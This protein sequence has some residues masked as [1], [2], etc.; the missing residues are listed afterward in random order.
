MVFKFACDAFREV[1]SIRSGVRITELD[2]ADWGVMREQ[3]FHFLFVGTDH[4]C[5]G[6]GYLSSVYPR[7]WFSAQNCSCL[8][9]TWILYPWPSFCK[10]GELPFQFLF[11]CVVSSMQELPHSHSHWLLLE[12]LSCWH[13]HEHVLTEQFLYWLL[14]TYRV[15]HVGWISMV[16]PILPICPCLHI[17][18]FLPR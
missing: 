17:M 14:K 16:G 10:D 18:P 6:R 8:L 4:L 3:H 1:Q 2:N 13:G 9:S 15:S 7:V 5:K 11:P 12:H